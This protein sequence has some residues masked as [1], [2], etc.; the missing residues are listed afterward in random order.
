M[1]KLTILLENTAGA[2]AQ[3]GGDLEELATIRQLGSSVSGHAGRLLPRYLPLLCERLRSG[4]RG[5][6]WQRLLKRAQR[7]AGARNMSS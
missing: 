2:G 1:R 4:T 5:Q 6:A 7:D 3:L